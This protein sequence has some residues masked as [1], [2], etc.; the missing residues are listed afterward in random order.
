MHCC[1]NGTLFF[2][3]N[4]YVLSIH[5]SKR[6]RGIVR[7]LG[8]WRKKGTFQI[9]SQFFSKFMP[10][11]VVMRDFEHSGL[12][13]RFVSCNKTLASGDKMAGTRRNIRIT[14]K[15]RDGA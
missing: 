7:S 3:K 9:Y 10:K 4:D 15:R 14:V 11:M 5:I 1:S 8:E 2:L 13:A 12:G 6:L